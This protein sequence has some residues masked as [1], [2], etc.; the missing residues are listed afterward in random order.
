MGILFSILQKHFARMC[1]L[2]MIVGSSAQEM[3]LPEEHRVL[4][5]YVALQKGKTAVFGCCT[6]YCVCGI[7]AN[8]RKEW[9]SAVF[10]HETR[11]C[12]G[13]NDGCVLVRRRPG[14]ER[15]TCRNTLVV[16]SKTLTASLY[17]K[18]AIQHIVLPFM[19]SI[20]RIVFQEDNA[21]PSAAVITQRTQQC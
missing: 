6:S 15:E 18:L 21:R 11:F 13:A 16:D 17:V 1:S 7:R 12:L 10:S 2:C 3:E 8:W 9:R 5:G 14:R 19:Y 20:Q 4:G